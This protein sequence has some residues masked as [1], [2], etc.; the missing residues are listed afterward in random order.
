MFFFLCFWQLFGFLIQLLRRNEVLLLQR[1]KPSQS[2]AQFCDQANCA[3]RTCLPAGRCSS[4]EY[5]LSQKAY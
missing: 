2:S 1:Q 4:Q 5:G 3:S